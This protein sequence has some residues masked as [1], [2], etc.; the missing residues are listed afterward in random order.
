MNT[1]SGSFRNAFLWGLG[2]L[3][4]GL[5]VWPT[6][7]TLTE[8]ELAS[9][10]DSGDDYSISTGMVDAE[11][12]GIFILDQK[13]GILS[14]MVLGSRTGKFNALYA[15]DVAADLA[16]GQVRKPR[17]RL[18]TGYADLKVRGAGG[19]RPAKTVV[20]VLEET[21]SR[22]AAYGFFWS[23]STAKGGKGQQGF[24]QLLDSGQLRPDIEG[25]GAIGGVVEETGG[26]IKE[27]SINSGDIKT[28]GTI[29]E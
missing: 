28:G 16:L 14:C 22:F 25:G 4:V 26:R 21:S 19:Q 9:G 7:Q 2:S 1:Q 6:I 8:P 15:G 11:M 3:I 24:L 17:F 23:T 5:L 27:G 29:K 20:Y 13:T 12:E 18:V 10:T